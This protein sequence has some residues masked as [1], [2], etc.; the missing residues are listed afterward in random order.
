MIFIFLFHQQ[1]KTQ[2]SHIDSIL[3]LVEIKKQYYQMEISG[4]K[5]MY[6]PMEFGKADF[7]INQQIAIEELKNADIALID[8]VYSD[9][10]AKADFSMLN[11]KRLQT[12]SK[13]L[14]GVFSNNRTEFRKI[15][16]TGAYNRNAA[17]SMVHGFYI[18]YRPK[19]GEEIAKIEIKK[20]HEILGTSTAKKGI[21]AAPDSTIEYCS[22]FSFYKDEVKDVWE[23]KKGYTRTVKKIA[24]KD[25]FK[26]KSVLD[27]KSFNKFYPDLKNLDSVYYVLDTKDGGCDYLPGLY[28]YESVD[29][30][31]SAVFKRHKWEKAVV[32]A[33]VTG[34]M[35]PYTGQLLLWLN[36]TANDGLKRLFIFFN[37]GDTKNDK[38][39]IIGKTG[40]I[41][42]VNTSRYEEVEKT[43]V[44]AMSNGYGGDAPEN[45]IEALINA[46]RLCAACDSVVMI[47]DNWAP[48]KDISLLSAI[49]KP[50]KVVLCGV[51][52]R[53]N[54]DYLN[55]ARKTKG[56]IHLIEKDIYDLAKMKEGEVIEIKG[57]TYKI[58]DGEFKEMATKIM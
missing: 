34:S 29:T 22:T 35:Y 41:Y 43:I 42:S 32:I 54:V 28:N 39:K 7:T 4:S 33:D 40:G 31:V 12:L 45:N 1:A 27:E 5:V 58:V 11:K 55:I 3:K 17:L 14:P 49:K 46:E 52:G 36:L 37:D 48:V 44:T 50:I 26:D 13:G 20:L 56:S 30:T 6:L 10:P 18:Y 25:I 53:I 16:Q 47:A 19:P 2:T 21:K 8:L 38:E 24:R 9:Y 57:R 51:Y 15:R 23:L